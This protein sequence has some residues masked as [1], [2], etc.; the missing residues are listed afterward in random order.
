MTEPAVTTVTNTTVYNQSLCEEAAKTIVRPRW[1]LL[2]V[3]FALLAVDAVLFFVIGEWFNGCMILLIAA[4]FLWLRY[5][6]SHKNI[7]KIAAGLQAQIRTLYHTDE[8]VSE[9]VIDHEKIHRIDSDKDLYH[10]DIKKFY[11]KEDLFM[12]VYQGNL[13][14]MV[15]KNGFAEG[16]AE[17]FLRLLGR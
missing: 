10:R 13:W 4:I 16:D 9:M 15:D 7:K 6:L 12:I 8:Y 1:K 14:L 5:F 17:Q 2:M 3:F 11:E